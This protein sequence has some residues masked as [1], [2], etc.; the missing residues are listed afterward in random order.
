MRMRFAKLGILALTMGASY[1]IYDSSY[2]WNLAHDLSWAGGPE[3][4]KA[5]RIKALLKLKEYSGTSNPIVRE[6]EQR[7]LDEQ[8]ANVEFESNTDIREIGPELKTEN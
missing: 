8:I 5:K 4:Y 2:E 6:R 7:Y 1:L 3:K